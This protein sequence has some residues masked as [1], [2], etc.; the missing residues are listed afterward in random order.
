MLIKT[1]ENK[2]Y[3]K[4]FKKEVF[5]IKLQTTIRVDHFN[6]TEKYFVTIY[7]VN[8]HYEIIK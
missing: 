2:I 7:H 5:S 4:I 8:A 6:V 1:R 3:I